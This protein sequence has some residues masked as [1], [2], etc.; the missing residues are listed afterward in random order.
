MENKKNIN[1]LL[2]SRGIFN[3]LSSGQALFS[4]FEYNVSYALLP[5]CLPGILHVFLLSVTVVFVCFSKIN[6]FENNL[7]IRVSNS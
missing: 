2:V 1:Y 7:A 4:L 3:L 6:S 5:L